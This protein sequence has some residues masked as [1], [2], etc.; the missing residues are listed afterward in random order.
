MQADPV[1]EY[2]DTTIR[3]EGNAAHWLASTVLSNQHTVEELIDRKA[4]NGIYITPEIAENVNEYLNGLKREYRQPCVHEH[5][6]S[7]GNEYYR[8]NGRAD[9]IGT[10]F[11]TL[12]IDDCKFGYTIVEPE[13][14]W[15]LISH[16]IGYTF[17]LEHKPERIQFTIHQPRAPHRNGRMRSWIISYQQLM[18]LYNELTAAL[19]NPSNQ[20]NTGQHCYKCA[21]FVGCPARQDAE[22]NCIEV[23][24]MAYNAEISND[25][26]ALRRDMIDRAINM[27]NQSKKAYDEQIIHRIKN[28]Q[29]VPNYMVETDFANRSWNENVTPDLIKIMC[30]IDVT[31]TTMMTPKQAETAGMPVELGKTLTTRKPKGPKLVRADANKKATKYFGTK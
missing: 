10:D 25:D 31:R 5:D 14:N 2:R 6:T 7:F 26:L 20:L 23:S 22:L 16:A 21:S 3:D 13:Y 30:G 28:N 1:T 18:M 12:Y 27:L 17:N 15:T 4:P 29:I 19:S 11:Q 9:F 8:V 24:H